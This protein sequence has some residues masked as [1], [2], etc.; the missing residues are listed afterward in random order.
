MHQLSLGIT[1]PITLPMRL[2]AQSKPARR[3]DGGGHRVN[4]V[5]HHSRQRGLTFMQ[6]VTGAVGDHGLRRI[7]TFTV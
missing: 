6:F 2:M 5:L 4:G 1:E 7:R 3:I